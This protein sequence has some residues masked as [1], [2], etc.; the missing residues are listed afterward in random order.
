M[1]LYYFQAYAKFSGVS[2]KTNLSSN[3]FKTPNGRL[4]LLRAGM[5]ILD[6]VKD[7]LP[8]FAKHYPDCIL[9]DKNYADVMAYDA[10]LREKLFPALQYI[11]YEIYS[12][13]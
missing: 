2:L 3:P 12:L 1:V 7:I 10:L 11:W 6:T 13:Y 4:P 5:N 8:F 9:T